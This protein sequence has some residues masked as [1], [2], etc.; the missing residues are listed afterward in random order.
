MPEKPI[1]D[2]FRYFDVVA[3]AI[4]ILVAAGWLLG[5][6]GPHGRAAAGWGTPV[7][8]VATWIG[9]IALRRWVYRQTT[10]WLS[11]VQLTWTMEPDLM[12]APVAAGVTATSRT[13]RSMA[14]GR[15]DKSI[16][17]G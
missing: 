6:S 4:G 14:E 16:S 2:G 7:V 10:P 13:T 9:F 12:S 1:S 3:L 5:P 8:L 11:V 17:R 15:V